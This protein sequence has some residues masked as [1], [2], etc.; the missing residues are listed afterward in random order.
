MFRFLFSLPILTLFLCACGSR[1]PNQLLEPPRDNVTEIAEQL[2]AD[3]ETSMVV[4]V[5]TLP[6]RVWDAATGEQAFVAYEAGEDRDHAHRESGNMIPRFRSLEDKKAPA[7]AIE[8]LFSGADSLE[9]S[10]W[11]LLRALR[12]SIDYHKHWGV[13]YYRLSP[14][15]ELLPRTF[16]WP[17]PMH[18]IQRA[19]GEVTIATDWV[20]FSQ[21]S[22][23]EL[24]CTLDTDMEP[25][26]ASETPAVRMLALLR[27]IRNGGARIIVQYETR[28]L[29]ACRGSLLAQ[30][31]L[32]AFRFDV[33]SA[34]NRV[35]VFGQDDRGW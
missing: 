8:R 20:D 5:D 23:Q 10:K 26:L 6:A 9:S 18:V 19:G 25:M 17:T 11:T 7:F 2:K 32:A 1:A 12:D 3:L 31:R 24:R 15:T 27:P 28:G 22:K 34:I 4:F 13:A 14:A 33:W 30:D 21:L 16:V 29:S 35:A